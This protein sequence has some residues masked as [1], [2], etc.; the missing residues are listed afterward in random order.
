MDSVTS[1]VAEYVKGYAPCDPPSQQ[2]TWE[3][4]L[5]VFH[6]MGKKPPAACQLEMFTPTSADADYW[7]QHKHDTVL[8]NVG[9]IADLTYPTPTPVAAVDL[10]FNSQWFQLLMDNRHELAGT[11]FLSVII[12]CCVPTSLLE[13]IIRGVYAGSITLDADNV[14]AVYRAADAMQVRRL[15]PFMGTM[16]CRLSC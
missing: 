14:E 3:P 11:D 8:F 4:R 7:E 13:A 16:F 6:T 9:L 5:N 10:A 15:D 1:V 2:F 12:P